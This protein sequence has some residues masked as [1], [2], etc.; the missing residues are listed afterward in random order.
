MLISM[1]TMTR[2]QRA[3]RAALRAAKNLAYDSSR[4]ST[5]EE[6]VALADYILYGRGTEEPTPVQDRPS[7]RS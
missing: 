5:P 1:W 6:V 3:R 4:V 2:E 7:R